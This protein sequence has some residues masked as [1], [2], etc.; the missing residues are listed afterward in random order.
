MK[1]RLMVLFFLFTCK[2]ISQNTFVKSYGTS[3]PNFC[4][5]FCISPD[6][7]YLLGVE[8]IIAPNP[9]NIN[10]VLLKTDHNGAIQWQR[11]F[12]DSF[13][14]IIN[15]IVSTL[16]KGY[17]IGATSMFD[18]PYQCNLLI[19]KTDSAGNT[20]WVRRVESFNTDITLQV[21]ESKNGGFLV[22]S[23]SDS[24]FGGYKH[25]LLSKFD[26]NG[27][28]LWSKKYT[29]TYN[30]CPQSCVE[31]SNGDIAVAAYSN[32][33][34]PNTGTME[35]AVVFMTDNSGS[36]KWSK[37]F[38]TLYDDIP[39]YITRNY[40]DELFICGKTYFINTAWDLLFLRLDKNGNKLFSMFYDA[41][42][43]DGEIARRITITKDGGCAFFGDI[44]TFDERNVFLLKLNSNNNIS[45][46]HQYPL[47]PQFT[48]Y[49]FDGY[50]TSDDGFVFSGDNGT[51]NDRQSFLI[52][53]NSSGD[54]GCSVSSLNFSLNN[55]LLADT[56]ISLQQNDFTVAVQAD[57][58]FEIADNQFPQVRCE[59]Q[60]PVPEFSYS[61]TD[62]CKQFCFNFFNL[63]LNNPSS[64]SWEFTGSSTP[65]SAIEN[66]QHICFNGEGIYSVKL[67]VT[68][69]LGSSSIIK[70]I[71]PLN[72]NCPEDTFQIPNIFTPNADG[73]NDLFYI[74]GLPEN[75][76][77]KVYNRW[78]QSMFEM[79][80]KRTFW[81]GKTKNGS[82]AVSG[83]Y[84]YILNLGLNDKLTS[85]RGTVTLTR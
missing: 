18:Q 73:D 20:Q 69:P 35:N 49:P 68:N 39:F 41:G 26:I 21:I 7:G 16:D 2:G 46:A 80:N 8:S 65:V 50:Q 3:F 11:A 6:K 12:I 17:L 59:L 1:T 31:L 47:N 44:G 54:P 61:Q 60:L 10:F 76:S 4:N 51:F 45:W 23:L 56:I 81:N 83:V 53:T 38:S 28:L 66:P 25:T 62:S 70:T 52:K 22:C 71:H 67:T 48:N 14:V 79:Q 34:P 30:L 29:A 78:G 63:S 57:T 13:S 27:N 72:N 9:T 42:T 58:L 84:Y 37:V 85:Y 5:A 75:Y 15:S 40:N 33:Y 24:I 82:D 55:Q 77:L 19:I 64:F 32:G 43:F 36:L 74:K